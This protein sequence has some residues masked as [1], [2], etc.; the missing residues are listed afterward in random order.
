MDYMSLIHY[1]NL[2]HCV[3]S[4]FDVCDYAY[5]MLCVLIDSWFT[6]VLSTWAAGAVYLVLFLLS[7]VYRD[8]KIIQ[9]YDNS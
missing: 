5:S 3:P 2:Q 8:D 1:L 7:C 9:V 6:P 4:L